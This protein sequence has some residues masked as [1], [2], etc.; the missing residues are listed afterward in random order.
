MRPA[1]GPR[2]ASGTR[3][4]GKYEIQE[5]LGRGGMGEVYRAVDLKLKREVALKI[6]PPQASHAGLAAALANEAEAIAS[7][8]HPHIVHIN[9]FDVIDGR[10]C[11]DTNYIRGR[12]LAA[13]AGGQPLTPRQIAATLHPI[14][15]ALAYAH[16][17]GV[18]H[19][20]IKPQNIY[21]GSQPG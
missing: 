6:A 12:D 18:L 15:E 19:R 14:C 9:S 17:R 21:L 3:L 13:H 2:L 20:D 7:L 10:P 11:F 5:F 8:S 1:R 4:G 16:G